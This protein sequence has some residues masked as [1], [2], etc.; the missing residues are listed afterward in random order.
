MKRTKD[1]RSSVNL[2]IGALISLGFIFISFEW[3][4]SEIR[5]TVFHD[6]PDQAFIPVQQ[7][8]I[9]REKDKKMAVPIPNSS[10]EKL[11]IVDDISIEIIDEPVFSE[12]PSVE[13][14]PVFVSDIPATTDIID[15]PLPHVEIMPKFPGGEE[16]LYKFL[17]SNIKYPQI[18]REIGIA[19]R[20]YVQFVI[21]T[22]GSVSQ[23]KVVRGKDRTLDDEALRIVGLMPK[24]S[25]GI[26]NGQKVRVKMTL[27]VNF[28][29]R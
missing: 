12:E 24:W 15:E 20:V 17:R 22:D 26:Q 11:D 3:S 28:V 29:L 10:Y 21:E 2:L 19:G 9:Y 23:V 7:V 14:V 16:A 1:Q 25:P 5:V 27:P 4:T 6:Q 8:P 13:A 18:A